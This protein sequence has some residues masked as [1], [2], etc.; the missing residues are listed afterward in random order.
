MKSIET[1]KKR[2]VEEFAEKVKENYFLF[3]GKE[4]CSD[5]D[6][7]LLLTKY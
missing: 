6:A 1:E 3:L 4:I 5:I 7:E 2:A